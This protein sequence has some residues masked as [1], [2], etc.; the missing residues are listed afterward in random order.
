MKIVYL[1]SEISFYDDKE[2]RT[3]KKVFESEEGASKYA[4]ELA[5]EILY[6]SEFDEETWNQIELAFYNLTSDD[7]NFDNNEE[8]SYPNNIENYYRRQ[9]EIDKLEFDTYV[10]IL[11]NEFPDSTKE[12]LEIRLTKQFDYLDHQYEDID[13]CIDKIEYIA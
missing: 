2:I 6:H 5:E 10:E 8:Y 3:P 7:P 13:I 1:V 12:D 9:A 11:M 4:S